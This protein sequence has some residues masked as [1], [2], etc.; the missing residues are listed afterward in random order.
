MKTRYTM[1]RFF[2][3]A[4]LL[5]LFYQAAGQTA[6][7]KPQ[8]HFGFNPG[9][10]RQLFDYATLI[11]YLEKVDQA[12]SRVHMETIGESSMGKPI[13][14]VFF[15]SPGNIQRL[16]QLKRINRELALNDQLGEEKRDQYIR[17][18]KVFFAATLSMHSS[19]VGPS[20]AAPLVAHKLA[21][22][23]DPDTLKW[24]KDVVYMMVPSHNPDGMDM[25]VN[26]YNEY[27]GTKYEGSSMPGVYHKYVGHNINRDFVTLSQEE[28][29]AISRLF[30][31]T[32]F[33]QVM[34]E[35]HQMGSTG[36][37]YFVPPNHDPIAENIDAGLWNWI[38]L[39]G[40]NMIKDM[41]REELAGVS[42]HY[43]F[44]NYWPG[45]TETC[46][47]K[48]VISFLTESASARYATP[49]Y[50]EKNELRVR[51]KGLSEYKKSV[52]MPL[53]WEGGWWKLKDITDYEVVSTLS[54]IKSCANHKD[55]ILRFR[56]DLCKREVHRGKNEPP[57]Y[58][59]FPRHQHDKSEMVELV[60][61]LERHGVER[62]SLQQSL[63]IAGRQFQKGDVVIPL[64]Q[65]FRPFIKEVLEKQKF[66]VRHYTP[67][68][69]VIRPYDV[70]SWSLPLH[71]GVDC[72][73]IDVRSA[74]LE[75][76]LN[77]IEGK[78]TLMNGISDPYEALV[79]P[80]KNNES[81]RVAFMADSNGLDIRYTLDDVQVNGQVIREGAF[82][83]PYSRSGREDVEKI[84]K[85]LTVEP[86]V[87]TK[88]ADFD[89]RAL[90]M[91]RIGVVETYTHD[92]DAGWTRYLFD[93]YHI[94]YD[95][96]HPDQVNKLELRDYQVIVFPDN[97]KSVLLSGQYERDNYY[98]MSSYP[99]EFVKGMGKDGLRKL[100]EYVNDGGRILA[101]GN[102]TDLFMGKQTIER[103]GEEKETFKL[104]VSNRADRLRADGFYCPGSFVRVMLDK[105]SVYTTGLPEKIGA[106]YRGDP[107]L[108][109]SVPIFDM[110]RRVLG[111]FPEDDILLSGYAEEEKAIAE[112]PALAW[113]QKGKGRIFMLSFQPQFRASTPVNYKLIFNSLLF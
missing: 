97:S 3:F 22:T 108:Q 61:L 101:W 33:P 109:T 77:K 16:D 19:E 102:S 81:Y 38:G 95:V 88:S 69:E 55:D 113:V 48:N 74:D 42:Q 53:P 91:P 100:M 51:G 73:Q 45:S 94:P 93:Q 41:T 40:M 56:N 18:G 70:A 87:L 98:R 23:Q 62:F 9:A 112:A 47:W 43:A 76:A 14:V 20:Q 111:H 37:R 8:E 21:T 30:S 36:P 92:M 46:L 58:Y 86:I 60:N 49:I 57:Y 72:Y 79:F 104:P 75:G 85:Q 67:G 11:D 107:V 4:V 106:F 28:N 7:I 65:A 105:N 12:S 78:Y 103:E 89:T 29:Q 1:L 64:A 80:V 25:V 32:W 27:R 99:P 59:I 34:V 2:L 66:P 35:K 68:G 63:V 84:L 26:H 31:H 39:F 52:N 71:R 44:D 54:A 110:D 13:Y 17:E 90:E 96:I 50:V 6:I 83:L 82:V 15:S 10:D 5:G 24:L